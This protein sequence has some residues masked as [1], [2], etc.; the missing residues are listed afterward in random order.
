LKKKNVFVKI[1]KNRNGGIKMIIIEIYDPAM[2]CS[3]GVCGPSIDPELLRMSTVVS[4]LTEKGYS[5]QR[6]N[7]SQEPQAFVANKTVSN[8]LAANGV[9]ALPIILVDGEIVKS[10]VYPTNAEFASYLNIDESQLTKKKMTMTWKND[11][12][13]NTGCC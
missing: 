7:L 9:K 8:H 4:T 6:Y 11:C 5:I 1:L 2:C 3:T 13:G 10:G 12:S